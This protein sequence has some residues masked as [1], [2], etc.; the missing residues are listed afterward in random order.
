MTGKLVLST[1]VLA[2][3]L[4]ACGSA[5]RFYEGPARPQSDVAILK[6]QSGI[7][8]GGAEIKRI[9][10][11]AVTGIKKEIELLPGRYRVDV[12]YHQAGGYEVHSTAP[13]SASFN[14]QAGHV[15]ELKGVVS[16]RTWRPQITDLTTGK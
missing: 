15:Y 13:V 11:K 5:T 4:T 3:A 6:E 10:G 2:A 14:A 7:L 8:P 9:N 16:G 12:E 1:V